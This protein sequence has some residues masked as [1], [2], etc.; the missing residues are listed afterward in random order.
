MYYNNY[1]RHSHR[2]NIYTCDTHI[3]NE[4]YCKRAIEL[5][6][7]N[8]FSTEHGY[9]GDIFEIVELAEKYGL[10]PIFAIEG[11]IVENPLEKDKSNFHIVIVPTN[12]IYRRKLNKILSHANKDGYYYKPRIFVDDLL[13]YPKEA[14]C[15]TT[16]CCGGL[17]KNE[18][19][20]RIFNKLYNHF[21]DNVFL[22]TQTHT[23]ADQININKLAIKLSEELG[24]KLIHANDSHYIYPDQAE[25]RLLF[26]KGKGVN[27]GDEDTYILD[28]PDSDTIIKRYKKQGVLNNKQIEESLKTTLIF[29]N[30]H[31]ISINKQIKMPNIYKNLSKEERYDLL[32]NKI[33]ANFSNI[34]SEDNITEEELPLYRKAI[35]EELQVIKD[36]IQ[37]NTMDYFLLNEK[38]IDRAI[39]VYN[40]VLTTTSRGSAGAYYLN[41]LL[42]ITQL[43]RI[44][45]KIPLYYE[46]FMSSARLLGENPPYTSSL[47]DCDFNVSDPIPF[48][49]ASQDI[50]GENG[51]KWMTAY[52]TMQEGEAFRNTCRALDIPF[53]EF[54]DVAKDL[55]NYRNDKRWKPIIEKS[56]KFIDVIVSASPHP[57]SNILLDNDLEEELGVLKIGEF[58]CCPITSSESDAWKYLKNDYLTV[59]TVTLTKNI[60]DRIG[61]PRMSL[62]ELEKALDEKVWDI[63]AKGLTCTVNQIDSDSATEMVKI[64]KPH[65]IAEISKFTGIIRPNFSAFRDNYIHRREYHNKYQVMDKLFESTDHYIIFQENLMQF[66][67]WLGIKPSDSIGLI[68]KISKKKIHQ[69]DFDNLTLTLKENWKKNNGTY[70]GFDETWADMQPMMEYGYNSPH[71]LAMAYDSLYGAYLKSH[72]PYEYYCEALN[73]Y[74]GDSIRTNKMTKELEYFGIKL[75]TPKFKYSKGEYFASKE[76]NS[77]YKGIGSIKY[78]NENVANELYDLSQHKTYTNF[79]DLLQDIKECTSCDSRQLDILIKL[80]FFDCFGASEKLL[81]IVEIYNAIYS[82]QQFKKEK[83]PE[84]LTID[85]L[86]KYANTETEKMFKDVDKTNLIKELII[87]LPN[88]EIPIAETL[89]AHKE[90][91]GYIDYT[92]TKLNKRYVLITDTD[93][94]YTPKVDTYCL[95]N[96][97]TCQCKIQKQLFKQKPLKPNDIIYINSM[98]SKYGCK[99]V[100]EKKDAKGKLKP[101]FKEDKSTTVWWIND[102]TIINNFDEVLEELNE[103]ESN[104]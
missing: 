97:K 69:E 83:L 42:G 30:I 103:E 31:N 84:F 93:T 74:Q 76:T 63:Y 8:L 17:L 66:F 53:E 95:Q 51:C 71:G 81:K 7:K 90:Y 56:Q 88:K 68:K 18:S 79:F 41:R 87:Q 80:N 100:G 23:S 43:D 57:C 22:E 44:R 24:L 58:Y 3:K 2:S 78:L 101:I 45:A 5:G 15:I 67:E 64:Y 60:F 72:Y 6:H 21:G 12:D 36:T 9:G 10:N 29:D 73:M 77:I 28:Y 20:I 49:K 14:F 19:G 102:Y 4:D 89:K 35:E 1:H 50:L 32:R 98:Q 16:A 26:L 40:G 75:K 96:S 11:Y 65:S 38:I 37:I 86:R 52:G 62:V 104:R 61:I 54:N 91:L 70:E 47:P 48:I 99:K 85:L 39:N 92:N 34:I 25:D 33:Y 94:K 46:R 27:Y 13:Q 55:D 59:S 82:K